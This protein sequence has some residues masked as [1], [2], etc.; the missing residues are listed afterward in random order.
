MGERS[1]SSGPPGS[2]AGSG[3]SQYATPSS[4]SGGQ[5]L[6]RLVEAPR[7]VDVDL[8]RQVARDAAHRADALDVETVAAAELQL[9]APEPIERLL[10]AAGHVVGIA[11]PDRP[12]RRRPG[13]TEPEQPPDGLAEELALQVVQRGVD[14]RARGELARGQALHH[15][16]ERERVVAQQ[17]RVLL[18][19]R[20]RRLGRLA[21]S[22]RSGCASPKPET[23]EC[24]SSTTTTSSLSRALREMTNVSASSSVTI[25]A[26][27]STAGTYQRQT[28]GRLASPRRQ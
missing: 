5:R 9:E 8:Q 18:D 26:E 19:V 13:A 21:R 16:L 2:P 12:A 10:G 15:L 27:T 25:R 22:G 17:L 1:F 6:E 23:P 20:L 4:A 28:A 24:R 3:C 7:L 11:E 14:R